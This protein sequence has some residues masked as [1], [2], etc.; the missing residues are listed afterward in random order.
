MTV[1][2]IPVEGPCR[3]LLADSDL[4]KAGS[5]MH[6]PLEFRILPEIVLAFG[7]QNRP[8]LAINERATELWSRYDPAFG[9]HAD[10]ND[11]ILG[12]V[13]VFATA[14][15]DLPAHVIREFGA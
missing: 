7:E 11:F 5:V 6:G 3:E 2:W 13:L 10:G 8:T 15:Q 1:L 12:N 9:K 14:E 4:R